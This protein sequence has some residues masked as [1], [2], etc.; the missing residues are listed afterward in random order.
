MTEAAKARRL[1]WSL[2]DGAATITLPDSG[3]TFRAE[4][5]RDVGAQ[6]LFDAKALLAARLNL[7]GIVTSG[8]Q[9]IASGRSPEDAYARAAEYQKHARTAER[10]VWDACMAVIELMLA[11]PQA[12]LWRKLLV[13]PSDELLALAVTLLDAEGLSEDDRESLRRG[14]LYEMGFAEPE[15]DGSFRSCECAEMHQRGRCPNWPP[16]PWTKKAKLAWN[17]WRTANVGGKV[18]VDLVYIEGRAI[19]DRIKQEVEAVSLER[20]VEE[21]SEEWAKKSKPDL[22]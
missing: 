6:D 1:A 19:L 3:L 4:F 21:A 9:A 7:F 12:G 15:P 10:S 22:S 14:A 18:E 16:F 13:D 20:A 8:L 2:G 17:A 5:R 11:P